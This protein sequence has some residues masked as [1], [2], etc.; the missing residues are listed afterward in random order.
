M[1]HGFA[2]RVHLGDTGAPPGPHAPN[3]TAD[4]SAAVNDLLS[5]TFT[6]QLRAITKDNG[7]LPDDRYGGRWNPLLKNVETPPDDHGAS[8]CSEHVLAVALWT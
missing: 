8:T 7:V 3:I 1:K 2:V 4:V 5:D 6:D